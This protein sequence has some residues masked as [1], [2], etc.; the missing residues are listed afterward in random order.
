MNNASPLR[1]AVI[2]A[3]MAGKAHAAAYRAASTVFESHLPPVELVA[4]GDVNQQ[5]GSAAAERFGFARTETDWRNIAKADDIDVVSVVVANHL[6]REVVEGLL[7]SGKH[8]LCE[9][10]ISDSIVDAEAMADDARA[11]SQ[12]AR[13]GLTFRRAPAINAIRDLMS[14]GTLG[15]LLHLN[16]WYWA[17]Y[18]IDPQAPMSW[19]YRGAPGSGALADLGSHLTDVAEFLCGPVQTVTGGG[20]S[21]VIGS[22]P[23][24]IGDVVG[25]ELVEVSDEHEPVEN[26]DYARF[27]AEF[28]TG[29]GT[30]QV[31]RVAAGQPNTMGFEVF[32]ENGSARWDLSRPAEFGLFEGQ[33]RTAL[34][35][36][37]RIILG[38][39][40]PYVAGGLAMD[41]PGV[42]FGQNEMFIYQARAFL[43]E[44]A[45][46]GEDESLPRCA[47]FEEGVHNMK[48]LDAVAASAA[49]QGSRRVV[50]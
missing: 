14:D 46:L 42:G 44:V 21:T 35:G 22:R 3:G 49:D 48:V 6:H 20:L 40:H 25:H 37:K 24:P 17:D 16:A 34:G 19:R 18:G 13:L 29:A 30:L 28:A 38:P 10:P 26:D 47:A 33:G 36:E 31:S 5:F 43:D 39:E 8:V 9:K 7:A 1:V 11:S 4:I 2:G 41:A 45:G 15:R 50:S 32:G 23:K 12:V 27:S